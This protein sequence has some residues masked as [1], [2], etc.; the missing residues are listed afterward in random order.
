MKKTLV[1]LAA[2]AAAS[3][4]AQQLPSGANPNPTQ[5]GVAIT[6]A[7]DVGYGALTYQGGNKFN[8]VSYN[9]TTTSQIDFSGVEDLG[10]GMKADFW[11]ESDINPTTAY[12]TGVPSFNGLNTSATAQA[13]T[14]SSGVQAASTWGNGQVKV[15][16]GG[17]FG[18]VAAGAVNNAL[19][20]A[21][22]WSSPFG[23]AYGSGFGITS[24]ASGGGYGSSAKVRYDNSVRYLTPELVSGLRLSLVYRGKNDAP[25]NS[26]FSSTSGWQALSGVREIAG[27]YSQGPLNLAYVNQVDDGN[28]VAG[29]PLTATT[30]SGVSSGARFS[31]NT[32]AVNYTMGATTIYGGLQNVSNDTTTANKTSRYGVQYVMG[33]WTF[34]AAYSSLKTATNTQSTVTGFGADYALSKMTSLYVRDEHVND[35]AGKLASD[36]ATSAANGVVAAGYATST[37]SVRNRLMVGVRTS[38]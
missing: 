36:L 27:I 28:G 14:V 24:T 21:N 11:F 33:Q 29:T 35:G 19:L 16:L 32:L 38:F 3:S 23:T 4:F 12:N 26:D 1:A 34:K 6:G 15:G 22:Q 31:N 8:G 7:L 20:D 10:G 13:S 17:A 37:D 25:A 18:Y 30:T 5:N 2:F 9:G